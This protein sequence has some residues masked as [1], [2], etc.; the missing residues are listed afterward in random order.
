MTSAIVD[1]DEEADDEDEED[2]DEFPQLKGLPLHL[3]GVLDFGHT[4]P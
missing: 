4:I 2:D 3:A 1:D